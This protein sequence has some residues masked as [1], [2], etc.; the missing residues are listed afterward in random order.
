MTG[1]AESTRGIRTLPD[2]GGEL[3]GAESTW[4][5]AEAAVGRFVHDETP[6]GAVNG[7]NTSFALANSPVAGTLVL[8]EGGRRLLLTI[9]F[10]LSGSTITMTYAPPDGSALRADYRY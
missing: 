8:Y 3:T 5:S 1:V 6:T 10:S 7:V 2:E 9:D 4:V